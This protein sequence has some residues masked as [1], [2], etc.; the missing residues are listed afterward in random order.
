MAYLQDRAD[1]LLAELDAQDGEDHAHVLAHCLETATT[2][3]DLLGEFSRED[4]GLSGLQDDVQES[5]DMLLL[6]QLERSEDAA[7]DAVTLLLQL[8][9]DMADRGAA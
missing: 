7:N 8:K 2:L 6:M 1:R 4:A 5:A 3:S 9:K